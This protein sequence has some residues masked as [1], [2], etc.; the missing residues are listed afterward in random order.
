MLSLK[1]LIISIADVYSM[2]LFVYV[3]MS[4]LPTDRGILADINNVLAKLCDPYL[5]LFR[6]LIPPLGGIVDV[7]PIIALL[8][9]QL[10]VRLLIGLF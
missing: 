2:V 1:Y 5:N 8:V 9:L 10:G 7:T 6:K 3:M 4:W